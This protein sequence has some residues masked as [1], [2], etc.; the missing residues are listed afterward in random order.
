MND[1]EMTASSAK[2]ATEIPLVAA[3]AKAEAVVA[4]LAPFCQR[5]E[6]AGSIRRRRPV[7]HDIDIV[8]L[9]RDLAGLKAR[10]KRNSS[11]VS[12][13]P[14]NMII[15]HGGVQ[16]DLFFARPDEPALFEFQPT[17]YGSLL[18]CRTGSR[19]HNI[20]LCEVAR[21]RGFHWNP[22]WGIFEGPRC[23]ACAEEEDIFRT[24]G[25]TF[26]RPEDREK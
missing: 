6:I 15:E 10:A 22:Y 16:V 18:L 1:V 3:Q 13:G 9:P 21:R 2:P 25:L 5:L 19:E 7:V 4:A 8:C 23:M 11:V 20:W 14:M 17:N 24:L 12:E 26:I